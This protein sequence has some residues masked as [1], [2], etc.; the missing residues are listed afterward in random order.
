LVPGVTQLALD[1]AE[2][3]RAGMEVSVWELPPGLAFVW[4]KHVVDREPI[5]YEFLPLAIVATIYAVLLTFIRWYV[6]VRAQDLPFTVG[7]A[8]RL[9]LVGWF[10]SNFLPGSVSGDIIKAA[11]LAREQ[12]R[13]TVAV[14]TVLLDR[15]LALVALIWFVALVGAGFWAAGMLE[16]KG[17]RVLQTIVLSAW[18]IAGATLV[19]WVVLGVLPAHRAERFAGRLSR[20]RK[21]GHSAAEFWRAVWM[22]RCRQGSVALAMLIALAAFIG[23]V[24]AFYFSVRVLVE[25]S[26]EIPS[27]Q[28]HFLIVPIGLV[29]QA[30]PLFPG[31]AGIGEAGFGG[32]YA[33]LGCAPALG[34]LGSLV[35]RV[36]NWMLSLTGYLVYLW[37]KPAV[38]PEPVVKPSELTPVEA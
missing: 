4:Q 22:Y 38:Q 1:D 32:L 37:S 2:T 19:G 16:G 15:A 34:V 11:F 10:F 26:Q 9:G 3:I 35:L 6:L 27:W 18:A 5:H 28:A 33:L 17:E 8:I 13:R 31:G 25:P 20:L 36:I 24:L 30:M 21:V 12:S 14:A 23:F 29:I 7:N